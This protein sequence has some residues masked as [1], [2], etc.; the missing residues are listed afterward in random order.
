MEVFLSDEVT[1]IRDKSYG[2]GTP[3]SYKVGHTL[4]EIFIGE[5]WAMWG[6]LDL[7]YY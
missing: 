7:R 3:F 1:L 4:E 6:S 5:G 2:L